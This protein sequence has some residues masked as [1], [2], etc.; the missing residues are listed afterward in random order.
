MNSEAVDPGIRFNFTH[1]VRLSLYTIAGKQI[2]NMRNPGRLKSV[3]KLFSN[4]FLKRSKV[5]FIDLSPHFIEVFD[6]RTTFVDVQSISSICRGVSSVP[7]LLRRIKVIP[8]EEKEEEKRGD[9][10]CQ[11]S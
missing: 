1:L 11:G 10:R 4:R 5:T 9:V 2:K 6:N 3:K 8:L 7:Y